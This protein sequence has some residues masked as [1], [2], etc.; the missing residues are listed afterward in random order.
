MLHFFDFFHALITTFATFYQ[1]KVKKKKIYACF[2]IFSV[3]HFCP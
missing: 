2:L 1:A 3:V